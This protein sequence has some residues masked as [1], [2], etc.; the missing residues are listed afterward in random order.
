MKMAN[1]GK[2]V[3]AAA[4]RLRDAAGRLS[5]RVRED[6][7]GELRR[8]IEILD[9]VRVRL[10]RGYKSYDPN[11][12]Q[13]VSSGAVDLD[14]LLGFGLVGHELRVCE[15]LRA[16]MDGGC[17]G[18]LAALLDR[19]PAGYD[20]SSRL[21][22]GG[23][24]FSALCYAK[25][26]KAWELYRP[27][28]ALDGLY[29]N[30]PESP[31]MVA[32][33]RGFEKAVS[34]LLAQEGFCGE[35]EGVGCGQE[36]GGGK[37]NGSGKDS[38]FGSGLSPLWAAIYHHNPGVVALLLR[39][40]AKLSGGQDLI[41]ETVKYNRADVELFKVVLEALPSEEIGEAAVAGVIERHAAQSEAG[42]FMAAL[43]NR[44]LPEKERRDLGEQVPEGV[45]G[46][47]ASK[48]GAKL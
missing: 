45:P 8:Q 9:N 16:L 22:G 37:E 18:A 3:G 39:S 40:G 27:K 42:R 48:K 30:P 38:G 29:G 35:G 17:Y 15:I 2:W 21:Q 43:A 25:D 4:G 31:I 26:R 7:D 34:D 11:F 32:A 41:E 12:V 36:Q 20:E 13:E 5:L 33:R 46:A 23:D 6:D 44:L 19:L 10:A 47:G 14:K 1:F 28:L 24:F